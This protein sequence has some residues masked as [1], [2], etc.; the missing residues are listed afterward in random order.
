MKI[1]DLRKKSVD[2]L[3]SIELELLS[4]LYKK[5]N[6]ARAAKKMEKSHEIKSMKKTRSQILTLLTEI[7]ESNS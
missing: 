1:K 2:E 5:K 4:K 7:G 6:E 3:K